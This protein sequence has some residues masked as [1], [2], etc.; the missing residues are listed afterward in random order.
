MSQY[1]NLK[2]QYNEV[3]DSYDPWGSNIS[4]MFTIANELHMRG[5][6]P[7]E[8]EYGPG[9]VA[10]PR[11]EDDYLYEICKATNTE[12]LIKFG[13]VLERYDNKLRLADKNY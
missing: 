13:N 9:A 6:V 10:D 11:E 8:W 7:H 5:N 3:F 12:V 1:S 4:V 2:Q